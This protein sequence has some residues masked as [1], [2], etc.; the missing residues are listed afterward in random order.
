MSDETE[1]VPLLH[2]TEFTIEQDV[3]PETAQSIIDTIANRTSPKPDRRLVRHANGRMCWNPKETY[4]GEGVVGPDATFLGYICGCEPADFV[5]EMADHPAS[6]M[7]ATALTWEDTQR[8]YD[9]VFLQGDS[10]GGMPLPGAGAEYPRRPTVF[11]TATGGG[12]TAPT[13]AGRAGDSQPMP[14]ITGTGPVVH[15]QVMADL[16]ERLSLGVRRYGTPLRAFNGRSATQ[17]A[18]EE[19]LDLAVYLRQALDEDRE[20]AGALVVVLHAA[21]SY[22]NGRT[23]ARGSGEDP[24]V[25]S[26]LATVSLWLEGKAPQ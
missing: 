3:D 25:E 5:R 12:R 14:H 10:S 23:I 20:L 11:T 17:D 16:R 26:A 21:R 6:S 7:V 24:A 19:V 8:H 9:R 18:Y 1:R 13:R 22:A 4:Q 15:E 2:D